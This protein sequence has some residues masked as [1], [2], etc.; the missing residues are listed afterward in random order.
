[1]KEKRLTLVLGIVQNEKGEILIVEKQ[2]KEKNRF[3]IVLNWSFPGGKIEIN[4]TLSEAIERELI[5]ETGYKVKVVGLISKRIH[6]QF[7][8][9]IYY[10]RCEVVE[11]IAEIKDIEEIK[12]AAWVETKEIRNYITTDFDPKMAQLLGI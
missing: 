3:G 6:P 12:Q 8:V 7:P 10:Y 2:K 5:E 11:K 1:M 9:I 4:E